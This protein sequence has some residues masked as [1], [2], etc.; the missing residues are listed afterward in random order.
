[1]KYDIFIPSAPKDQHNLDLV[2]EQIFSN[3]DF[4]TI[5]VCTPNKVKSKIKDLR[6]NYILDDEVFKYDK[7][8]ISF[9]PNWTYQQVLKMFFDLGNEDFFLSIDC[10]SFILKKLDWFEEGK[11]I[12]RYGWEQLHAP[13]FDFNK[14]F[15][16]LNKS[17]PH[18]GIGDVGLFSKSICRDFLSFCKVK[19]KNEFLDLFCN[20]INPRCQM[21][22]FEIYSNYVN[23]Y[24]KGVYV[25]KKIIQHNEG[26]RLDLG[27]RWNDGE[28]AGLINKYSNTNVE[29]LQAHSW[30]I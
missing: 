23:E 10:D 28:I 3:L 20:K 26:R 27:Q 29:I 13:Y 9:R 5:Y 4:N 14:K 6:V 2:I 7:S 16:N 30:K 1:M 24:H 12:W 21:S 19:N 22:E 11:P 8:K 25:F 18:T 17:L 15:F